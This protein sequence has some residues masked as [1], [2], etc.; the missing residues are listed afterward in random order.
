VPTLPTEPVEPFFRPRAGENDV[1]VEGR[2][3][4]EDEATMFVVDDRGA[5]WSVDPQGAL[6]R[7]FVNSSVEQFAEF[8]VDVPRARS[9]LVGSSDDEADITLDELDLE[10]TSVDREA[11]QDADAFWAVVLEQL[12]QGLV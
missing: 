1:R 4:G 3:I 6:R 12:R 7:R 10:L 2:I 9:F 8:L 5:V 11:L